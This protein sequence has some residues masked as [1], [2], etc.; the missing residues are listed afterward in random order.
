VS[1]FEDPSLVDPC[2]GDG[3]CGVDVSVRGK[4]GGFTV[5]AFPDNVDFPAIE[6]AQAPIVPIGS[7]GPND[8]CRDSPA[9]PCRQFGHLVA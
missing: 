8:P 6:P 7:L 5:F 3:S 1:A 4:A 2:L 9:N